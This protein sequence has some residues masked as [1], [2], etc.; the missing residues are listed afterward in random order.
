MMKNGVKLKLLSLS[1]VFVLVASG[2]IAAGAT[3][4]FD[5]EPVEV[6][7]AVETSFLR[8]TTIRNELTY[9]GQIQP[10]R[11]VNVANMVTAEVTGINFEVGDVV[12]EGD[13]LFTVDATDIQNQLRQLN[14]SAQLANIG[15]E[16]AQYQLEQAAAQQRLQD[17]QQE[18][19]L[20]QAET[21]TAAT[22]QQ[23]YS[24][25]QRLRLWREYNRDDL[26]DI[27]RERRDLN[28]D[29]R[30]LERDFRRQGYVR[31]NWIENPRNPDAYLPYLGERYRRL[32]ELL[33]PLN[34]AYFQ[35][36]DELERRRNLAQQAEINRQQ[37]EASLRTAEGLLDIYQQDNREQVQIMAEFGLQSAQAQLE[38]ARA[39]IST[40]HANL[41]RATITS[42]ISGI[43]SARNVEVGQLAAGG[44]PFTIV[45]IDPVVVQVSVSESLIN[46]VSLGQEV[47]VVIQ[48]LNGEET[49]TGLV[50]II[51]PIAA[52]TS[53]FPVHIELDNA[54]GRIRPGMFSQVTFVESQSQNTFVVPK[55]VVQTDENGA[56][57]FVVRND[58][59]VRIPVRT[60]MET[61]NEIEI[62]SGVTE[63][64][65]IVMVGQEFLQEGMLLNVVAVDGKRSNG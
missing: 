58:H 25:A 1:M 65:Q 31:D 29:I 50:S 61:G 19:A 34:E 11:T 15:V 60:G 28:Q 46:S 6:G 45:Q 2:C 62:L 16:S 33:H 30:E 14:A 64:D 57:V 9:I 56:F 22:A 12:E 55:N 3:D 48:A 13:V 5:E 20:Q 40:V 21:A 54:D 52:A 49:L 32:T 38:S 36:E 24:D 44:V 51:S 26:R 10:V 8:R 4:G 39:S 53:T 23:Q 47:D 59:A 27:E 37:A 18:A 17:L 35:I 63:D 42:P 41:N 43:V 7:T